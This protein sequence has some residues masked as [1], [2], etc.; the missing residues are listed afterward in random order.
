MKYPNWE[1]VKEVML[2]DIH[3]MEEVFFKLLAKGQ[4][5]EAKKALSEIDTLILAMRYEE[6]HEALRERARTLL[7][8]YWEIRFPDQEV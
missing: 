6:E 2:W 5:P 3:N 8:R 1:N 4:L 7:H